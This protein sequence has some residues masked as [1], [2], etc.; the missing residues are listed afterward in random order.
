M[1]RNNNDDDPSFQSH[2]V[3]LLLEPFVGAQSVAAFLGVTRRQVLGMARRGVIP[4]HGLIDQG[5]GTRKL[6]RF[7]LSEVADA[8]A[9]GVRTPIQST[10]RPAAPVS[11]KEK[12]D[13]SSR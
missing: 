6:W 11:R 5:N 8:V 2:G 3:G 12:N 1:M 7:R 10:I 4:A 13:G 9:K